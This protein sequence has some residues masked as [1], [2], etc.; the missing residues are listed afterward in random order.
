MNGAVKT[1][2]VTQYIAAVPAVAGRHVH[3]AA[4][5]RGR[6]IGGDR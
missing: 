4:H 5:E 3:G 2:L 1:M 6:R